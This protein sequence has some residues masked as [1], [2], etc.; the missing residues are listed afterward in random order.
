MQS[1]ITGPAT[2]KMYTGKLYDHMEVTVIRGPLKQ[3]SGAVKG[4][5]IS[6]DGT[7][8]VVVHIETRMPPSVVCLPEN[9]VLERL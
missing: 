2:R 8:S 7:I 9:H 5:S 4:T 3:N 1:S 6:K